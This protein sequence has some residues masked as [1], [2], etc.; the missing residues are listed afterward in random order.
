MDEP[1]P[2]TVSYPVSAC[3]NATL[4]GRFGSVNELEEAVL[5]AVHQAGRQLYARAF[6]D[7]QEQWLLARAGRFSAQR[8]RS[9]S[10][11][12]WAIRH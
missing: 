2:A 6:K 11:P 9:S 10:N 8:W 12:P 3:V 5:S 1:C 4:S 7:L